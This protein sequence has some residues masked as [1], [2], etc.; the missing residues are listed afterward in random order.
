MSAEFAPAGEQVVSA[1][2][3]STVRTWDSGTA[4][5]EQ[6]LPHDDAVDSV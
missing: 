3:D 6:T 1:S 4:E 2:D 5:A